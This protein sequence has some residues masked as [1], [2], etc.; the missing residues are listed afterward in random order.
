MLPSCA[1]SVYQR[2]RTDILPVKQPDSSVSSHTITSQAAISND[3][4]ASSLSISTSLH[5]LSNGGKLSRLEWQTI[6][7]MLTGPANRSEENKVPWVL[8]SEARLPLLVDAAAKILAQ[9][10]LQPVVQEM[11]STSYLLNVA[12]LAANDRL[13]NNQ[14]W[15]FMRWAAQGDRLRMIKAVLQHKTLATVAITSR[16]LPF[17]I[18][19]GTVEDAEVWLDARLDTGGIPLRGTIPSSK[20]MDHALDHPREPILR[21]LLSRGFTFE[22]VGSLMPYLERYA[23]RRIY[24]PL[25]ILIKAGARLCADGRYPIF[26]RL[27]INDLRGERRIE[28]VKLLLEADMGVNYGP[29]HTPTC[30]EEDSLIFLAVTS[31]DA[32]LV[33]VLLQHGADPN[34]TNKVSVSFH[35]AFGWSG[36]EYVTPLE[37]AVVLSRHEMAELLLQ[38]GATSLVKHDKG[39]VNLQ[40]LALQGSDGRMAEL[41]STYYPHTCSD[42]QIRT[43]APSEGAILRSSLRSQGNNSRDVGIDR[44]QLDIITQLSDAICVG[45][46]ST[47]RILLDLGAD[48]NTCSWINARFYARP[49]LPTMGMVGWELQKLLWISTYERRCLVPP[50]VAAV[51][52]PG[53]T[54][55]LEI[56][57]LLIEAGAAVNPGEDSPGLSPLE[58]ACLSGNSEVV[59]LLLDAGATPCRSQVPCQEAGMLPTAVEAAM[60]SGSPQ[61]LER[62]LQSGARSDIDPSSSWVIM[63]LALSIESDQDMELAKM[64]IAIGVSPTLIWRT[65]SLIKPLL[66]GIRLMDEGH[67]E[68]LALLLQTS[69]KVDDF[70][71]F[72][73]I[74]NLESFP[75]AE[76]RVQQRQEDFALRLVVMLL[77]A[78]AQANSPASGEFDTALAA[79]VR[80][81]FVRVCKLLLER[82]ADPNAPLSDTFFHTALGLACVEADVE[83]IELL[84]SYE[85]DVNLS[86]ECQDDTKFSALQVAVFR[87]NLDISTLL[88]S[89]GADVNAPPRVSC[90]PRDCGVTGTALHM[91]ARNGDLPTA[92]L[93][94]E[95]GADTATENKLGCIPLEDAALYGRLDM[96]ALLLENDTGDE[97]AL[98]DRCQKAARI[99]RTASH[100]GVAEMLSQ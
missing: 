51:Q 42:C 18:R 12:H 93:L 10:E 7:N 71:L 96:V 75:D 44:P 57:R 3:S 22:M 56:A 97:D 90:E 88:L 6:I 81:R 80:K 84:L 45:D 31:G 53:T 61:T 59:S 65:E 62:M 4:S 82:G 8:R 83:I 32:D 67:V 47:V 35:T 49:P 17:A 15:D 100:Y 66:R 21:L 39:H 73:V 38:A 13:E 28:V 74:Q 89:R 94:L 5:K 79:A 48:P 29:H 55:D 87:G 76:P 77:D 20:I 11:V 16:L 40:H 25:P 41:L 46:L 1:S 52:R 92:R 86:N 72:L 23:S 30:S 69:K 2:S 43:A 98:R 34:T 99:A 95:W 36:R 26:S 85:A 54:H 24:K 27:A 78:G 14:S 9:F 60:L 19:L 33:S 64:I 37:A 91:A 58:A 68:L 50:L 63:A 70:V